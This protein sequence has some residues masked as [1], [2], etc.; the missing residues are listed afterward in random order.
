MKLTAQGGLQHHFWGDYCATI[1]LKFDDAADAA[2]ALPKLAPKNFPWEI[3]Q[4]NPAL[5]GVTVDSEHLK[6]LREQLARYGDVSK[7][8]SVDHSIDYGEPFTLVIE[9]EDP[10]QIALPI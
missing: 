3:N 1:G 10:L 6:L 9:V 4:I 7:M 2:L 8:D 5:L